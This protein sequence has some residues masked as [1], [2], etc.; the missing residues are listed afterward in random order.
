MA[1]ATKPAKKVI[2]SEPR[3]INLALRKP[4]VR[5]LQL[6]AKMT[7]GAT[8]PQIVEKAQVDKAWIHIL[9]GTDGPAEHTEQRT[10]V[11]SLITHKAVKLVTIGGK[12]DDIHEERFQITPAGRKMLEKA[13]KAQKE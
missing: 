7:A 6:L 9:V 13:L 8:R 1:T 3:E 10:R 5:V 2:K 12:G 11:R 4:Q